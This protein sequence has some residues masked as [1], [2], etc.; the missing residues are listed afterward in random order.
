MWSIVTADLASKPG[1]RNNVQNIMQPT[2]T[3]EVS[4]ARDAI[5]ATAS[6][7]GA[8]RSVSGLA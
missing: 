7:Q 8:E 1:L 2:R 5:D 6:K 3:R 4:E